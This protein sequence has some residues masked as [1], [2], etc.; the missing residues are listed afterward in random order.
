MFRLNWEVSCE[1]LF[2]FSSLGKTRLMP[3]RRMVPKYARNFYP[4]NHR[5][6]L[7]LRQLTHAC[8]LLDFLPS[9]HSRGEILVANCRANGRVTLVLRQTFQESQASNSSTRPVLYSR[10]LANANLRCFER[11]RP[12]FEMTVTRFWTVEEGVHNRP[13]TSSSSKLDHQPERRLLMIASNS[14]HTSS[15]RAGEPRGSRFPVA[16]DQKMQTP[17]RRNG[18]KEVIGSH[19]ITIII[20]RIELLARAW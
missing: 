7:R 5:S 14:I 15:L 1:V 17:V 16:M 19:D 4:P 2:E 6:G 20:I 18:G 8:R 13:A 9:I 10:G 3:P 11:V 12:P